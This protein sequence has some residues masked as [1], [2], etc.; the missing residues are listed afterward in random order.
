MNYEMRG[1]REG[2]LPYLSENLRAA[3][4]REF[5]ATYGH[6]RFL[7]GLERSI[8]GSTEAL[9]VCGPEGNPEFLFGVR[10]WTE[11]SAVIWACGTHRAKKHR[12]AF[13]KLGKPILNRWFDAYPALDYL[14]NF[15]HASNAE[16]HR[17]LQW[18]GAKLLPPIPCGPLGEPF[19]PFTIRRPNHV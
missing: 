10:L 7:S 2:D 13:L 4:V 11:K 19:I 17:W 5:L 16:H 6:T 9:V 15:T 14:M 3:D 8:A 12:K 1:V 18:C